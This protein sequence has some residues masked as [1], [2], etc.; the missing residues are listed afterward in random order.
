MIAVV[1]LAVPGQGR[2]VGYV[3]IG[4]G[5]GSV[6]HRR[7]RMLG[8]GGVVRRAG[9]HVAMKRD[10]LRPRQGQKT[11]ESYRPVHRERLAGGRRGV[12]R[13]GRVRDK[14]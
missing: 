8:R 14:P 5:A 4:R 2:V 7:G 12:K 13:I 3:L 9:P 10:H 11:K 6:V 1:A